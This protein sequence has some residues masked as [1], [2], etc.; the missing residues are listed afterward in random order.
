MRPLSTLA[1]LVAA[2]I[3]AGPAFAADAAAPED[4]AAPCLVYEG[5]ADLTGAWPLADR[6]GGGASIGFDAA[7]MA[8][9]LQAEI[10]A[11]VPFSR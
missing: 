1:L 6:I 8:S 4:C 2:A 10:G 11:S 9:T 5:T 3:A 7:G